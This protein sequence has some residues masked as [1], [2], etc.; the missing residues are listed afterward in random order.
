MVLFYFSTA[1]VVLCGVAKFSIIKRVE[2]LF[3]S[4]RP[5]SIS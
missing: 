5:K 2:D 1:F 4:D 3:I